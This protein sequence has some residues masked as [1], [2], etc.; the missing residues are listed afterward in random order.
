[1]IFLH[2]PKAAGTTLHRIIERQYPPAS[3]YSFGA[4]A[5][6]SVE[7]FKKLSEEQRSEIRVLK[8][9]MAF[10]LHSYLAQPSTYIT[11]MRHPVERTLSYYHFILRNPAHY[12]HDEVTS[13]KMSLRQ[14][15]EDNMTPD[16][17]NGQARLLSGFWNDI[18]TGQCTDDLLM[19]AKANLKDYFK[20]V[21][22]AERFD[23]SFLL[24]RRAFGWDYVFYS[25]ENV[26][27][28]RPG[29]ETHP[30]ETVEVIE[31]YNRQDMAL[32]QY[33][34]KLFASSIKQQGPLFGI[35]VRLFRGWKRAYG[36]YQ[37]RRSGPA[38]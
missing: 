21:G 16:L 35:E 6:D 31:K 38:T 20:V 27:Q 1:L 19:A 2:I 24:M 15:L 30:A 37:A 8:G 36:I 34:Q 26:T 7:A 28:N 5:H 9:H 18:P 10:G 22:L 3:I 4:D 29:Q 32:Y 23:E 11:L 13:Q 25:K 17:D 14:V 12:L 33:A